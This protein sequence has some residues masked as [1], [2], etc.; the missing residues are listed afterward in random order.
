MGQNNNRNNKIYIGGALI[1][2][3]LAA[4]V[5]TAVTMNATAEPVNRKEIVLTNENMPKTPQMEMQVFKL[6]NGK[7]IPRPD[8]GGYPI[9]A[10]NDHS[11]RIDLISHDTRDFD[12]LLRVYNANNATAE[13]AAFARVAFTEADKGFPKGLTA[14]LVPDDHLPLKANA[15]APAVLVVHTTPELAAGTYQIAVA[16]Q[17]DQDVDGE[18]VLSHVQGEII[19]IE[20][21]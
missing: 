1:A 15:Q 12:P 16:I 14:T 21:T 6:D 2:V 13:S 17:I 20:V 10:G 9:K 8:V 3:A 5:V 4:G 18:P 7:E 11:F 19:T